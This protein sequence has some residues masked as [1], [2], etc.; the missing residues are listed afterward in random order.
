MASDRD[1]QVVH[2]LERLDRQVEP[3]AEFANALRELLLAELAEPPAA[4]WRPRWRPAVLRLAAAA[5][6]ALVAIA[7]ATLTLRTA[8]ESAL[9]AL[10]DAQRQAAAVAPFRAVVSHRVGG[11][12]ALGTVGLAATG[13]DWVSVSELSYGGD[14]GW[15][16][17]VVRDSFA[18]AARRVV[19]D[20]RTLGIDRPEQRRYYVFTR[21]RA[22]SGVE[23][24]SP[25][26]TLSPRFRLFPVPPSVAPET[27]FR[28]RCR[29]GEDSVAAARPARR[30]TCGEREFRF[31]VWLDRE[32]GLLLKLASPGDVLEVKSIEYDVRFPRAEFRTEPPPGAAVVRIGGRR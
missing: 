31:S 28:E 4:R 23:R 32:T 20:G 22:R 2:V 7:A 5:T 18:P 16:R 29:V 21:T 10:R 17:L 12:L 30:L 13:E 19:W 26:A 14:A 6:V 15:Q 3:D 8:E 25:L 1:D 11:A 27:Y 9:A 24:L